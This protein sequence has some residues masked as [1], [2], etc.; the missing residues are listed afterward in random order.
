MI[1]YA[2]YVRNN[3][4]WCWSFAR[5]GDVKGDFRVGWWCWTFCCVR[6]SYVWTYSNS[7][8]GFR[9]MLWEQIW[10]GRVREYWVHLWYVVDI[11]DAASSEWL[12]RLITGL[13]LRGINNRIIV[14]LAVIWCSRFHVRHTSS[15]VDLHWYTARGRYNQCRCGTHLRSYILTA[16]W[17]VRLTRVVCIAT[18]WRLRWEPC[19]SSSS[20]ERASSHIA[21]ASAS[22]IPEILLL[23]MSLRVFAYPLLVPF[24]LLLC[25][26]CRIGIHLFAKYMEILRSAPHWEIATF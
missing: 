12:V 8:I 1:C 24:L 23:L 17:V 7:R 13:Q 20:V 25:Q 14:L 10:A 11:A 18:I 4:Y 21:S 6:T 9:W 5:R 15:G 19:T 26:G 22:R 3:N 16:V 2:S